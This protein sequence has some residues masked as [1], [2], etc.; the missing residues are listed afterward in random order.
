MSFGFE[1]FNESGVRTLSVT[2]ETAMLAAVV[3]VSPPRR[4][5]KHGQSTRYVYNYGHLGSRVVVLEA[6][7]N[8]IGVTLDMTGTTVTIDQKVSTSSSFR[9]GILL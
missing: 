9:L 7:V 5:D 1:T 8:G 4:E 6:T 2:G 3:V